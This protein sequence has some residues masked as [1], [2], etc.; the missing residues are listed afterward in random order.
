VKAYCVIMMMNFFATPCTGQY[1]K[2]RGV[3]KA[4]RHYCLA[5]KMDCLVEEAL[6][7]RSPKNQKRFVM[8][9]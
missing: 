1:W 7:L 8:Y 3:K 5:Y 9:G 6:I 4:S 2:G